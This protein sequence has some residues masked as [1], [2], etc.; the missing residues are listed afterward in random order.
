MNHSTIRLAS[1]IGLLLAFGIFTIGYFSAGRKPDPEEGGFW[2][3]EREAFYF[4]SVFLMIFAVLFTAGFFKGYLGGWFYPV[5]D[6]ASNFVLVPLMLALLYTARRRRRNV[7]WNP[8][9]R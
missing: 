6:N 8:F 9:R 1:A 7:V 5:W 2:I 4:W 3:S